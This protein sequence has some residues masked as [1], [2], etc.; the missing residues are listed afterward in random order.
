MARTARTFLTKA[1]ALSEDEIE[2]RLPVWMAL[3]DLFLD[4][5]LDK[6]WYGAIAKRI[7]ASRFTHDE[8]TAALWDDVFPALADNLRVPAGEWGCFDRDWLK[9]RILTVRSDPAA[10]MSKYRGIIS[11]EEVRAIILDSWNRIRA[12]LP[13][14]F[15]EAAGACN[16]QPN[17]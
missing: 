8:V 1:V 15:T 9:T 7:A 4:T 10:A 16:E 17:S 14:E 2:R 3:S 5:E 12:H 6:A 11:R 13:V